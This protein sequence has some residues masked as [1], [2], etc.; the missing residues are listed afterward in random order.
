MKIQTVRDNI[1]KDEIGITLSHEHLVI[2]LERVRKNKDSTFGY[3]DLII[4]EI[5][6]AKNLGVKTFV[7][8][9]TNDM[10]RN[11]IELKKLSEKCNVN[12]IASTGFYL[13]EY[14]Y[15]FINSKSKNFIADIFI[16][17]LTKGIDN[18]NIKAGIIGELATGSKIRNGEKKVLEA[19]CIAQKELGCAVN[20]H[21]NLGTLANEQIKIF[22]ENKV[23]PE[24]IILGHI[25]LS[26]D[27]EYMINILSKGYNIAFDTIGKINYLSDEKRLE[28]L[29]T[30]INKGYDKQILLSQDISR[31]SYFTDEK[32]HG[33]TTIMKSF[34]PKLK[35]NGVNEK[36]IEN[37]LIN[38]PGRILSF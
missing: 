36:I 4:K 2:D 8:L 33:Y 25:D 15:D 13:D 12:I 1:N 19:A 37:L 7:E 35:E 24:K 26:N 10:G 23:N 21:C 38:N 31:I 3:S 34:I 14:H 11:V 17:E 9:T 18:T 27:T 32:Y 6:K 22:E 29:I 5:E 30:L 28:N 16:K 20:T